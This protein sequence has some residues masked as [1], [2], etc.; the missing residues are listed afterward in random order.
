MNG[1]RFGWWGS[2]RHGG[3]L[4]APSKLEE[5]F[6]AEV[7]PL[8]PGLETWLRRDLTR[9]DTGRA[10]DRARF[11]DTVLE[12]VLRLGWP[13]GDGRDV[14]RWLKGPDV[15]PEWA[16]QAVTG[17]GVKP[18]RVWLG[19]NGAILPVFVA[20]SERLGVGRGRRD[21]ARVSEWLRK[22]GRRIALLTNA[23]QWRLVY[24]GLDHEAFA[25][26]DT[27]LWFEEGGTGLQVMALRVLVGLDALTPEREGEP[28]RLL[29]AIEA[30]RKGQAELS[31]VLGERVRLAVELLIREHGA[32]LAALEGVEPR[33]IY[34]A[35]TRMMMRLI[36]VLFA[37]ARDLLPRDNPRYHGSY[38]LQGLR[39]SLDAVGRGSGAERLRHR[40]GGWPRILGLF[41]L[42]H[43]GSPHEALPVLRYGGGLFEP[44]DRTA[45]DPV[46]RALAVLEDRQRAPSD[47]VVHQVLELLT[48]SKVKVRQGRAA[49]WVD[50][51]VEFSDLSTE[52]IGILYEG[53]LDY[54]LRAA[55]E[56]DPVVFLNLGDEPALP[57][58]RLEGLDDAAV[59]KLV[60]QFNKKARAAVVSEAEGEE[61]DENVEDDVEGDV[62]EQDHEDDD[63][64]EA[65]RNDEEAG[66][67]DQV[68]GQDDHDHADDD[69]SRQAGRQRAVAWARRAVA[70]GVLVRKPRGRG[71]EARRAYEAEL[72]KAAE[73]IV[74]RVVLPGEWY[75]VRFGGTRK[76]SGTFYTRPAL[77][78]PTV[79]RTLRPLAYQ[80]PEGMQEDTATVADWR[81]RKPEEVLALKVCDPACGSGSFLVGSLRFLTAA[82]AESLWAHGRIQQQG[83]QTLVTL[84]EGRPGGASLAEELL[85]CRPDEEQFDARLRGRLKR[86]VV[87]RCLYGVD[88]DPLAVE[89]CR[90]A[91]WVETMD[92]SLPFSFLDHKIKCGNALV[93]CW[94]DRFRHYPALAWERQGGDEGHSNGVHFPRGARGGA[95]KAAKEEVKTQLREAITGARTLWERI[96]GHTPGEIHDEALAVL[97]QMHR[98]PVHETEARAAFYRERIV[99]SPTLER[100]REAFDA[101]CAVWFWPADKLDV[102]PLPLS[103]A[104][105][106]AEA[107]A[108]VAALTR[109]HHFFHWEIEFPDV[110]AREQSGFDTVVG[111]PPWDIQK[112][113]SKEFFSNLEPLYR[114]YG[115]QEALRR[116][117]E[118]FREREADEGRWLEYNSRFK[119][120]SNFVKH[121][122]SPFGDGAAEGSGFSLARGRG[123]AELHEAWAR[124]RARSG[125][126]ADPEHPFIHQGSADI[127]SYKLFLEQSHALLR[128]DG[129]LGMIAPSGLYTD[130]GTTELR[131]L[132]LTRC[133]WEW[134]FGFENRDRI[135]DIHRSF[136]FGPVIV[137]KGGETEAI[138]AAFM[139][140][141]LADWEEGENHVIPYRRAQVERF[142]PNTFAIL[143]L[144]N[145]RDLEILEKIYA[146]SVLLGDQSDDGWKIKYAREF[147]MTNDSK[148]FP[149]RPQWEAKGYRGDEYGRWLLGKWHERERSSPGDR[150]IARWEMA[151]GVI[152]SQDG[153]AWIHED[154]VED[155]ALPLY[156][157][158]MI[159][160]FDFS[161]KGWVS[162][163]GRRAVWRDIG[164]TEAKPLEPQFLMGIGHFLER[165]AG[166]G[167]FR[168]A[169]GG[170]LGFMDVTSATNTRTMIASVVGDVPSGNKVPILVGPSP[171]LLVGL[172]NSYVYDFALRSRLGGTTL[173]FFIAEET[174]LPRRST[175][176]DLFREIGVL[177][178]RLTVLHPMFGPIW[179]RYRDSLG[180]S[181]W[182][183]L[184][185]VTEH[186][187]K[188][189]RA[190]V[191]AAVAM[192]CGLDRD[193]F[194]WVLHDCDRLTSALSDSQ[195]TRLLDPKGF[196][197]V[198][199]GQ[200]PELRSTTLALIAFQDLERM[201]YP[202][203][204]WNLPGHVR[205]ADFGLGRDARAAT[206]LPVAG[207]LGDRFYP[208]QLEQSAEESWK[209]CE[210]HARNILGETGF[211]QLQHE[212]AAGKP[213][214]AAR[215]VPAR[216]VAE[217]RPLDYDA[218]PQ[219]GHQPDLFK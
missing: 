46:R 124:Q 13:D 99:G 208:F 189:I 49:T 207:A 130:K 17:E 150:A 127:N 104:A 178:A 88:L 209:E 77:A 112:P 161:E 52:Y 56:G 139:H 61:E 122:G 131:K 191:D 108:I 148:L 110:F 51:P 94:F 31:S 105:L 38:G 86:Y 195:G 43:E 159:G 204:Q 119:T 68:L 10:E 33:H 3:L 59:K 114:T 217:D 41:R 100:L 66:Q 198:D 218:G 90:L 73:Q 211:R 200:E 118:L 27:G 36:V 64:H 185:A 214:Y 143:E 23:R 121:A 137:A 69:E 201:R 160:Q 85:P 70:A 62:E 67:E 212:I 109:E 75:L 126:Y 157:G 57:L 146:N 135:F 26:W 6:A 58:S 199:K 54:E 91:L 74:L 60:D 25:E 138:R 65:D 106:S 216:R 22:A 37:E 83:D 215:E 149:P 154:E 166:G 180:S 8:R 15:P 72:A 206:S 34:L 156:E 133:R 117:T 11:L 50:A 71:A 145:R 115:K 140:R 63:D 42:V 19:A 158:R 18:R 147:D 163:R 28:A 153:E 183:T 48:R 179:L 101:W 132:F 111:N 40:F 176:S 182:R 92:R 193:E 53:L 142:S 95:I 5:F 123:S 202:P 170:K 136:K 162:G 194:A 197:R 181:P 107:T 32:A 144:R 81:P 141:D 2:L 134:L 80:L 192:L 20:D 47:A 175:H 219:A 172:L 165:C 210:L 103:L 171:L 129:R 21:A 84:A 35:A 167:A 44:G 55:A 16:H 120:L 196:W 205:L 97:E 30:S 113:N 78:S 82:L 190:V 7:E 12:P 174:P 87:E 76:G 1:E 29:A 14:G 125:G 4:I 93:G 151:P 173:N 168:A 155:V 89:L 184:W 188:R 45:G 116:Q 203:G 128:S 98:L 39:E 79:H 9:L 213:P 169:D 177:S 186:E 96:D 102:A 24:A 187:R 152:L 164:W